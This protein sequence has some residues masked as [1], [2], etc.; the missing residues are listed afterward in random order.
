MEA[1]SLIK[2]LIT[3]SVLI[4][5]RN[6]EKYIEKLISSL[7][8][9][10]FPKDKFEIIVIDGM[11]NDNTRVILNKYIEKSDGKI[12]MFNNEKKTLAPGWNI[13]I[14]EAKGDYVLRIDGHTKVNS[15]FLNN[16]WEVIKENPDV[17]CVGGTITSKGIGFQGEVNEYV[18]SHPFGVGNSKFRT[19]KSDWEGYV[20]TVPYGAYKKEVFTTVGLF[21]EN[22]V[23]NE[24]LDFHKRMHDKGM[25]FFL[26]SKIQ[27]VYFVR[28]SLKGLINKSLGDG[29][30]TII[31]DR[32]TPGA[33]KAR[34]KVPLFAFVFGFL[35][36]ILA[37]FIGIAF[38]MLVF[39]IS[40]YLILNLLSSKGIVAERSLKHFLPCMFTFFCLHFF[41]G[42]GSFMAFFRKEY[43]IK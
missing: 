3:F 43:W 37:P 13:G 28:D 8:N 32:I 35:L 9:Q 33:L 31:A 15:N 41:R 14:Q 25:K 39:I 21:N 16:Y 34:H 22:L 30:W 23:R 10:K 4:V 19:L 29:Q 38:W 20:D 27:S 17:S 7:M 24:D 5:T 42:L 11:S 36:L 18:Y 1:T 40:A 6:E 2:N 12:R 26:S